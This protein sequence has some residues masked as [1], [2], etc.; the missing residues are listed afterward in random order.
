[1]AVAVILLSATLFMEISL[2]VNDIYSMSLML[3]TAGVAIIFYLNRFEP[4]YIEIEDNNVNICYINKMIFK[5]KD[6]IL[7]KDN[8][9]VSNRTKIVLVYIIMIF[10]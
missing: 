3:A 7:Q 9:T 1:M 2:P 6:T 10:W 4:D 8:L 5:R